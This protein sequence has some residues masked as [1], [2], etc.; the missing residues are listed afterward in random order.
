MVRLLI[1]DDLSASK[2]NKAL[3]YSLDNSKNEVG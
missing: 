3:L 1:A 2:V